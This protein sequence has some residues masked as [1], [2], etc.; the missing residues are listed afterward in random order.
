MATEGKSEEKKRTVDAETARLELERFLDL[1]RIPKRKRNDLY[2]EGIKEL[3][4]AVEEGNM[5]F[6]FDQK[7]V[8]YI[9]LHPLTRKDGGTFNKLVMRMVLGVSQALANMKD[10]DTTDGDEKSLAMLATLAGVAP[11]ILRLAKNSLGESGL[12]TTDYHLLRYY[13]LFFLV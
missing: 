7:T 10:V 11:A 4:Y 13:A 12:D 2:K 3:A 8:T 9:L 6:D 1:K 5:I